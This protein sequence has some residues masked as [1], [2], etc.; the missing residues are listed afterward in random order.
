M[1]N[2]GIIGAGR[3]SR[4]FAAG[5]R[6]S[7]ECRLAAVASRDPM[8]AEAIAAE[9]GAP[10]AHSS[11]AALLADPQ[12][13]AVYIALPNSM[14]AE[15]AIHA[16]T[17]GKHVLCEKPLA[18][19]AADAEAMFTAARSNQVWLM[20]A[21]MYRFHPRTIALQELIRSGAVGAIQFIRAG[22]SFSLD[23][24]GDVRWNP[25]LAGG[26]LY[27]AGCYPLNLA[28]AL[29]GETPQRAWATARW[30]QSGVDETLAA[31]VEYPN[32]AIAQITCSFRASFQ[33]QVQI[34]GNDGVIEIDQCFTMHPDQ[35][36]HIR[37]WR[38]NHFAQLER[39]EIAPTNH[40]RLE[41]EGF[42]QLIQAG[43]GT[44]GL[45][46]MP[47]IET[48]DNLATIEALLKSAR[49]NQTVML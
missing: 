2:W 5:L 14:H 22:F 48:L 47:L 42:A 33:Q 24:P 13:Q 25:D 7:Q 32:G 49:T 34:V 15:W 43:H 19:T 26:A 3:I 4:K 20:E 9:L 6:E 46:E 11:Y 41:A 44:S 28:R 10:V 12:V 29:I 27:D 36:T 40:Y 21:F 45:P 39:I 31:T 23:R 30:S 38:G 1:L 35:P 18:A 17:A 8:R 37:L 16:A